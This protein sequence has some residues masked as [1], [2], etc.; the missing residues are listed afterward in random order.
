[1]IP[2]ERSPSAQSRG[3]GPVGRGAVVLAERLGDEVSGP[4]YPERSEGGLDRC[5]G[6]EGVEPHRDRE[7]DRQLVVGHGH[8]RSDGRIAVVDDEAEA[9]RLEGEQRGYQFGLNASAQLF[10][11][12][13]RTIPH[14]VHEF[15]HNRSSLVTAWSL[16]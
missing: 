1:M 10:G 3:L 7:S 16:I 13:A 15:L 2:G 8:R 14:E 5:S 6:V 12:D 4:A 11:R 9:T